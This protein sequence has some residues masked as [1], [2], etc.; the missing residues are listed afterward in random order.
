MS[1]YHAAF[2]LSSALVVFS[3]FSSPF[4][5]DSLLAARVRGWVSRPAFPMNLSFFCSFLGT[6]TSPFAIGLARGV[7]RLAR[8]R[9]ELFAH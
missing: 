7:Y 1:C 2:P 4:P 6:T 8:I 9:A 3:P 5:L